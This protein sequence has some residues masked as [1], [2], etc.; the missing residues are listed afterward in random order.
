MK[1]LFLFLCALM[2]CTQGSCQESWIDYSDTD[3]EYSIGYP[4]NWTMIIQQ[5]EPPNFDLQSVLITGEHA[6]AF[7]TCRHND[8]RNTITLSNSVNYM[9]YE[10]QINFLIY[11]VLSRQDCDRKDADEAITLTTLERYNESSP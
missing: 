9:I 2:I 1:I 3:W 10:G 4:T 6:Q 7:I 8:P 11:T 5:N